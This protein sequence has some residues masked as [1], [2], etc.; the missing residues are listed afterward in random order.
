MVL[1]S[2]AAVRRNHRAVGGVLLRLRKAFRPAEGALRVREVASGIEIE[3]R[4]N[5]KLSDSSLRLHGVLGLF[6]DVARRILS[7]AINPM[8]ASES[9]FSIR[10]HE[11]AAKPNPVA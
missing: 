10:N 4:Q 1:F 11:I 8:L 9:I 2:I 6:S 7:E 5:E 3:R